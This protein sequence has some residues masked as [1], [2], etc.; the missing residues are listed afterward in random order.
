MTHVR[1]QTHN[2]HSQIRD[3]A[4]ANICTQLFP[5]LP[6]STMLTSTRI[7]TT[8]TTTIIFD[9]Y[10]CYYYDENTTTSKTTPNTA[11][12]PTTNTTSV[13][14][15]MGFRGPSFCVPC[16]ICDNAFAIIPS[17]TL[18]DC[19]Q[20]YDYKHCAIEAILVW[21]ASINPQIFQSVELI[22]W[23][24]DYKFF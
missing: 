3:H 14:T 23:E 20:L 8:I 21:G 10:C 6:F 24:I 12:K 19:V 18:C 2:T 16:R 22:W 7:T 15:L 13:Q 17:Q 9:Y 4:G 5:S 11:T 1:T